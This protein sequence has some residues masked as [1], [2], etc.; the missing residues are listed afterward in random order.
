MSC[1]TLFLYSSFLIQLFFGAEH[2]WRQIILGDIP[3]LAKTSI[4]RNDQ[5]QISKVG[6]RCPD[7]QKLITRF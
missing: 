1:P 6:A 4:L 2:F 7:H 3:P 5:N